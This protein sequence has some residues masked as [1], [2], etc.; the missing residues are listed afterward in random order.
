[1]QS[2]GNLGSIVAGVIA[3]FLVLVCLFYLSFTFVSSKHET[4]AENYATKISGPNGTDSIYNQ[5]YK[6][7]MDSLSEKPV[8]LGYSLNEVRKWGVGLGLDLKGG[9]NVILQVDMPEMLRSMSTG[10][11]SVFERALTATNTLVRN[12]KADDYVGTFVGEYR[13]IDPN[14]DFSTIFVDIKPGTSADNVA[15]ILKKEVKDRVETS[16]TS[17]LRKRIDQFG[18]VSPNIQ[19]LQGKDG[20][21]LLEL[22][23]VKDHERVRELLQR[24]AN[25]EFYETYTVNQ[26]APSLQALAA[27]VAADTTYTGAPLMSYF[28]NQEYAGGATVAF[29]ADAKSIAEVN[30]ILNSAAAKQILPSDLKLRWSVKPKVVTARD[31]NGNPVERNL[32]Y[33]LYALK[34]T[35][36]KAILDGSCVVEARADYND[37]QRGNE[38][39][40][41]MNAEGSR[42]WA[43]I[44]TQAAVNKDQI[45]ILLD[46]QV[47]SAPV[48][49]TAIEGGSSQITGNFTTDEARDLANVLK[50]GKMTAKVNIISDMVVG[51]SLGAE[52]IQAGIISFIVALVLLMIFMMC[53]YGVIPGLIANFGLICNLFFTIGILASFQA[54]LTMSGIAGI[55]LAL[56]MAVDANVL[57]YERAKEELRAGKNARTAIM[58]GYSN[59]F[60]AI[61]D[62]NLTSII[63]GIILLFFGTGPIKG[64]ATTLIIGIV[65]SFFT[66]VYLSR[67]IFIWGAKS[68]AFQN[69]TFTTSLSRKMFTS[70]SINFIAQRKASFAVVGIVVAVVLVSFFTRGLNQGIDFSGG[71]NYIVKFEKPVST[72]DVL[73]AVQPE[74]PNSSVSVI[75]IQSSN[76]VRIST[77][78][79]IDSD[80]P[81]TEKEITDKLYKSLTPFLRDGMT[82]D[83]FS[84]TDASQGIVQ[85]QK[86]GPSIANDMRNDAY[87]AVVLSLI[88][89]FL[90]ILLRFRN[91]AFSVGALA[92]VSFTAFAIIGFY[93]LFWG[94]LPFAMEIDQTFIAAI[95]TVIGYQINDTVVVFDRVRENT[96]LYPK[97]D[98]FTTINSSINSTLGR[99]IMTSSSTLL[100]L[101]CIFILGGD[102][103]R[104]FTFAMIFGVIIGTLATIY[105]AAPVAYI[106]DSRRKRAVKA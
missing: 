61:F 100:V 31:N 66:A 56:G 94:I 19:V 6:H 82:E 2:K 63:T 89:M 77:N 80:D 4:A 50:S 47:Y 68:K 49:Q 102:A 11:D 70:S 60:S 93:S 8:Y 27:A 99:T 53:F 46:D 105:V 33:E 48:V 98:F 75:T 23:G 38:V 26:V 37:R 5:A 41:T 12:N 71:R 76:Q 67:L 58:E 62:S 81:N 25:L 72:T 97:Q 87:I 84:T 88:A 30:A 35:N 74:F 83:E 36:G 1:M 42:A 22:P 10:A 17:V 96:G 14:A 34:T 7:Y 18:V 92:A 16:A 44:T 106:T 3:I 69:L 64:F 90:Y 45:A 15:S 32:G 73:K 24:S 59:A 20:Q 51:P 39:S 101:L 78:Y 52:A 13:R 65:C 9:M 28:Q 40:M 21:I 29:V 79:L 54:V 85:S 104:S 86:V 43:R 55:V 95:L 57:I 91:V 103:I